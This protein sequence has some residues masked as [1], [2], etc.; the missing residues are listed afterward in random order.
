MPVDETTGAADGVSERDR[1]A[2]AATA[3]AR[4]AEDD[5]LEEGLTALSQLATGRI[6]L[7]DTLLR[8]AQFASRAIPGASGVGLTLLEEGRADTIVAT[9]SFVAE[10][11]AVQYGLGQGPCIS[12]VDD[13]QSVISGSLATDPR[14]P[15]FGPQSAGFGVHSS[16]SIPLIT[17]D[18]VLGCMNVYAHDKDVFDERA[19][20]LGDCFAV[21]AAIA[22][23]NAQILAESKRLAV[24]L[25]KALNNRMIVER[26]I[27]VLM[28]RSGDSADGA[29]AKIRTMSQ[30]DHQKLDVIAQKIVD[31]AVRRAHARRTG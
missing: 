12:A 2:N 3:V 10:M 29:M 5:D 15:Q 30:S 26:A 18:G 14:W 24:H 13:R 8:V 7:E 20:S 21:P 25:R 27:G 1:E 22:V 16:L 31:T 23:Q 17:S 6:G 28:T 19:E 11:D 4:A 9:E